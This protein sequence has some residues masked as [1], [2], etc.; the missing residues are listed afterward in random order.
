VWVQGDSLTGLGTAGI[1]IEGNSIYDNGQ[2]GIMLGDIPVDANGNPVTDPN[3]VDHVI[4]TPYPTGTPQGLQAWPNN[5]QIFP[6]LLAASSGSNTVVLGTLSSTPSTSFTLDFYANSAADPSGFGQ[7]QFYLGAEAVTTDASGNASFLVTLPSDT[8]AGEMI[9]ATATDSS[10]DTSEFSADIT[11]DPVGTSQAG[12]A[13]ALSG[14][15]S[16]GSVQVSFDGAA[17]GTTFNA[18]GTLAVEGSTGA[19]DTYTVN[20]GSTLT[21]PISLVGG[22]ADSG[23]TLIVN[24]DDSPTNVIDK[25]SGQITWGSPVTETIYRSGIPNT[26][27]N[28][29]GTS[30]NYVD[31]PG[32]NTII[33]GGPGANTIAITGTTGDGVVINGGPTT[34]TYVAALGNL[35]GQVTIDNTNAGATDTLIVNAPINGDTV[36]L[37]GN[38]VTQDSQAVV[39]NAPLADITVDDGSSNDQGG[40]TV[41][42]GSLSVPV[43]SLTLNGNQSN[44][45]VDQNV[46]VPTITYTDV[47]QGPT[48]SAGGPY[49]ITYGQ[50]LTLDG[51]GSTD[52]DGN[53]LTYSWTING[54]AD[55]ASG[56]EPVLSYSQLE[57][58][59]IVVGQSFDV[60][61][62]VDDGLGHYA[63][64]DMSLTVDKANLIVQANNQSK[65]YGDT[66][67]A[68]TSTIIGAENG[69]TFTINYASAGAAATA[70]VGSY[71]ITQTI[72]GAALSN[73]NLTNISGT[74][75]VD[76]AA[77]GQSVT[78]S[79][80][81][82]VR[83]TLEG[84]DSQTPSDK[85]VFTI[86]SLPA[87][88]T[89]YHGKNLV[90]A[91]ETFTGPP[92][93]K[94]VADPGSYGA[95]DSFTFTV[96]DRLELVSAPATVSID[97]PPLAVAQSTRVTEGGQIQ[98]TLAG[99][100]AST[101]TANLVFT[102][103][104]LPSKGTLY[105]GGVPV[106]A[107]QTFTG[108]PALVYAPDLG[109]AKTTDSFTFTVTDSLG[110][111][112]Y[113]A[114]VTIAI[115]AATPTITIGG[116]PFTYDDTA[117]AATVTATGVGGVSVSGSI[118]VTYNGSHTV[119]TKAG[120][121]N[122]AVKFTSSD[123]D[124][125]NATGSGTIIIAPAAPTLVVS[126]GP[127]TYDGNTHAAKV[128]A[129]GVSGENVAGAF[130]VNYNGSP[131]V[132]TDAGT[133]IVSITFTSSNVNYAS[134]TVPYAGSIT[135]N[136]ANLEVSVNN[137]VMLAGNSPPV[138]T[139][140]IGGLIG[141]DNVTATYTTTATSAS[142]PGSYAISATLSGS[143]LGNYTV[144][145]TSG[146]L[147]VVTTGGDTNASGG[148]A[149]SFWDSAANTKKITAK[150]LQTLEALNLAGATT[151]AAQLQAWLQGSTASNVSAG[152][153]LS[154]QTADME[155]NVFAA[156]VKSTDVVYAGQLLQFNTLANPI[157]GLDSGGFITIGNLLAAASAALDTNGGGA[158]SSLWQAYELA[159]AQA[160]QAANNNT[161]FVQQAVPAGS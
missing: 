84:S 58:L 104:S 83:I 129:T 151:T 155:L 24:G 127:F 106:Q 26:V 62:Q 46:T 16:A 116:G 147:Y 40:S 79:S 17:L 98:I 1:D 137:N 11:A 148:Q 5:S 35:L 114:T 128:K 4:P 82:K 2:R 159:L 122:V 144:Q 30:Q 139:G 89:L 110:L 95:I 91:G 8:S 37:A 13:I 78:V 61:V 43:Q 100:D 145:I 118:D 161:S 92:K 150:D 160:L 85:L 32:G 70:P 87:D 42:V 59:G 76:P 28:A 93:L 54:Q 12:E 64:A 31:D 86:T 154:A 29:N 6:D 66:F 10:G 15:A 75:T 65:A 14:G 120:T 88:G 45:A 73:Y 39:V 53:P 156:Y 67:S 132:P 140:V 113:P 34:N 153:L 102:V 3:L 81:D 68:F 55:A 105:S 9:S 124:Y 96:T 77:F 80:K 50:P 143:A 133:Y 136:P 72:S 41:S 25:T 19:P 69:D 97:I 135:I 99:T 7:G 107:G 23:D 111:T 49:V 149:T 38:Q 142:V 94:Y 146:T 152:Y 117:H 157:V 22:G 63:T 60:S 57:A 20:F 125:T 71:P 112:S 74:L 123:S 115:D 56:V 18:I 158:S 134:V 141:G 138:F 27:I 131:T 36:A 101:P 21:T 121:Y 103:A 90:F 119:P 33:N 108:P 109:Y 44:F 51:F 126:G 130:T 47:S 48:A 52:P